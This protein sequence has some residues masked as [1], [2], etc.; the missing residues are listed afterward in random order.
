MA[1]PVRKTV[2]RVVFVNEGK[3]YEIYARSAGPSALIGFVEIEGLLFGERTTVLVDPTEEK[4]RTEFAG[5][6]RTLIPMHSVV[7]IDQVAKRGTA[8]IT[9]LTGAADKTR[10]LPS[11]L[12]VPGK[13][14][15][16][17]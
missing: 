7:R 4:L 17:S 9:A 3:V 16:S 6:E 13:G 10:P 8:K 1:S 14:D 12:L 5:V 11:P 2:Y 15:T